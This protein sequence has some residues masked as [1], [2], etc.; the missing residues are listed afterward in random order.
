MQFKQGWL[1]NN[2]GVKKEIIVKSALPNHVKD[3]LIG[4]SMVLIGIMYLTSTAFKNG[5][6]A[7]ERAEY[8]TMIDLGI[9]KE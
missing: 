9:I 7:F 3:V 5:S 2:D 6:K 8:Q 1:R 4:G